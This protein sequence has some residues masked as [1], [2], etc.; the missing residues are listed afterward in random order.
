MEHSFHLWASEL[1]LTERQEALSELGRREM[2][3]V[4]GVVLCEVLLVC[5]AAELLCERR[6]DE[7]QAFIAPLEYRLLLRWS[8]G[9]PR[10]QGSVA[11]EAKS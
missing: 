1:R 9:T 5:L 10:L 3:V 2:A 7:L 6:D 4:I 8:F 11:F